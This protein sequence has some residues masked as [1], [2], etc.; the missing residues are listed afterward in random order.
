MSQ[1]LLI[2]S[3]VQQQL[4]DVSDMSGIGIH[5]QIQCIDFALTTHRTRL[6]GHEY[7]KYSDPK[8]MMDFFNEKPG[9]DQYQ[10]LKSSADLAIIIRKSLT[11]YSVTV[12]K[13]VQSFKSTI[14]MRSD[15]LFGRFNMAQAVGSMMGAGHEQDKEPGPSTYWAYSYIMENN[16]CGVMASAKDRKCIPG[17][18][19]S[20]PRKVYPPGNSADGKKTGRLDANNALWV[21][22]N[23]FQL[24]RL[25]IEDH[26]CRSNDMYEPKL[27]DC[28]MNSET[29]ETHCDHAVPDQV[30]WC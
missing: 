2:F 5:W 16:Y 13:G 26:K 25:G 21:H 14:L 17:P 9:S 4:Q 28:F 8:S 19:F 29:I 20:N 23:R 30:V 11:P 24:A 10:R 6:F 12:H 15:F 27:L 1:K 18:F 22:H 3:T 7:A